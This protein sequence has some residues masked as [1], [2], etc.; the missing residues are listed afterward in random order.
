MLNTWM[1]SS[2]N[3]TF[4]C[5]CL[6]VINPWELEESSI[7]LPNF[8][9]THFQLSDSVAFWGNILLPGCVCY[10]AVAMETAIPNKKEKQNR[11]FCL[12]QDSALSPKSSSAP[13]LFF[14][15]IVCFQLFTFLLKR[16]SFHLSFQLFLKV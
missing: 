12:L 8:S 15:I 3:Y 14:Q 5:C 9:L 4:S 1:I 13:S 16:F 6:T 11:S 2:L 10:S 7:F